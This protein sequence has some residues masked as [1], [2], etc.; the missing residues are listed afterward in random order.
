M[1]LLF[2]ILETENYLDY[3]QRLLYFRQM[4]SETFFTFDIDGVLTKPEQRQPNPILLKFIASQLETEHPLALITGRTPHWLEDTIIRPLKSTVTSPS[5]LDYLFISSEKATVTI[6]FHHGEARQTI[7]PKYAVPRQIW[8]QMRQLAAGSQD[9]F[10]D[11]L[12]INIPS[13]EIVGGNPDEIARQKQVLQLMK[14]SI[15]NQI[16]AGHTD[17]VVLDEPGIALD[18]Q[19]ID[20][21][22]ANAADAFIEFFS[23]YRPSHVSLVVFGDTISDVRVAERFAERHFPI[24]FAYVGI[25]KLR[26]QPFRVLTPPD[27]LRFDE[28]TLAIIQGLE[29]NT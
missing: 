10:F 8:D 20:V 25:D 4:P 29:K 12:K 3:S 14:K 7:D 11:D 5:S 28:G 15:Q 18:V 19:H 13:L 17:Y 2:S 26:P 24:V 9:V 27:P 6:T 16:L 1:P 22:K 23:A 21:A